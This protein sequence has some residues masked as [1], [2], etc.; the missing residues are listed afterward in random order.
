MLYTV[1]FI[2]F[3]TLLWLFFSSFHFCLCVE[4]CLKTTH[5]ESRRELSFAHAKFYIILLSF[6]LHLGLLWLVFALN[7][8]II[9]FHNF[10]HTNE[11]FF[12]VKKKTAEFFYSKLRMCVVGW[13]SKKCFL[14]VFFK[15]KT[16]YS[17]E[18]IK[19]YFLIATRKIFTFS[20]W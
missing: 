12:V 15:T 9:I 13:L 8:N 3:P 11:T 7:K 18:V 6:S 17:Y 19:F 14:N 1:P 4:F 20:L 5:I 10:F 2:N 16:S